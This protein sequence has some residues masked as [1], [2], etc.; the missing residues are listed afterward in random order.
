MKVLLD[1]NVLCRLVE[2]VHVQHAV[3]TAATRKLS[4]AGN[5]LCLVPQVL[6]E[7]WVVVT[8]PLAQNGLGMTPCAANSAIDQWLKKLRLFQDERAVF[9]PWRQ[10]VRKYGV[11]GKS[12]HDARLVAA[13]VRHNVNRMVTFNIGDFARYSEIQVYT[14]EDVIDDKLATR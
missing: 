11:T 8:R 13:M 6:Y 1:T 2:I 12:A 5:T 3:A 7:Y 9:E 4:E 14:P 10:L